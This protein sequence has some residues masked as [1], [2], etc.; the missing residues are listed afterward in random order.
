[1]FVSQNS[2][3]SLNKTTIY[4]F[5]DKIKALVQF[6]RGLS[7][8]PT[9]YFFILKGMLTEV[10][11]S[12]QHNTEVIFYLLSAN[13]RTRRLNVLKCRFFKRLSGSTWQRKKPEA[14]AGL[15]P[16]CASSAVYLLRGS[17]RWPSGSSA[18][19]HIAGGERVWCRMMTWSSGRLFTPEWWRAMVWSQ[20]M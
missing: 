18:A 8:Y 13:N 15:R 9:F 19:R 10:T 11:C 7:S 6:S 20:T 5:I 12:V 3:K 2:C 4:Y 1:M 17:P 16:V 14:S